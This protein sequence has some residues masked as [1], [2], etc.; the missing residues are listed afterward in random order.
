M[1]FPSPKEV[2]SRYLGMSSEQQ[3]RLTAFDWLGIATPQTRDVVP[4]AEKLEHSYRQ[5]ARVLHPDKFEDHWG[6]KTASPEERAVLQAKITGIFTKMHSAYEILHGATPEETREKADAYFESL[7]VT[8]EE[9]SQVRRQKTQVYFNHLWENFNSLNPLDALKHTSPPRDTIVIDGGRYSVDP[10]PLLDRLSTMGPPFSHEDRENLKSIVFQSEKNSERTEKELRPYIREFIEVFFAVFGRQERRLLESKD[11]GSSKDPYV[12]AGA[13]YGGP[14]KIKVIEYL[15]IEMTP[16]NIDMLNILVSLGPDVS[17]M[18][19]SRCPEIA[20][21]LIKNLN[22]TSFITDVMDQVHVLSALERD[23]FNTLPPMDQERYLQHLCVGYQ[24]Q[25]RYLVYV[26]IEDGIHHVYHIDTLNYAKKKLLFP[27]EKKLP[28]HF[29]NISHRDHTQ[30][31]NK[32]R[33]S[34]DEMASV[35]FAKRAPETDPGV[36]F[37]RSPREGLS[38]SLGIGVFVKSRQGIYTCLAHLCDERGYRYGKDG[39][40]V[41]EPILSSELLR[42][43]QSR[44]SIGWDAIGD[45]DDI[46]HGDIKTTALLDALRKQKIITLPTHQ[47]AFI[48]DYHARVAP[49]E[50]D[51]RGDP[52]HHHSERP[53]LLDQSITSINAMELLQQN[54]FAR[55]NREKTRVLIENILCHDANILTLLH[56]AK[57]HELSE[58][59]IK[60]I[61]MT[62]VR[63]P[64]IASKTW[65]IK[66]IAAIFS[67]K[68]LPIIEHLFSADTES[69][70]QTDAWI[71]TDAREWHP[72][73]TLMIKTFNDATIDDACKKDILTVLLVFSASPSGKKILARGHLESLYQ[74]SQKVESNTLLN[75]KFR[76]ILQH[77]STEPYCVDQIQAHEPMA[78][79]LEDAVHSL[80]ARAALED[81]RKPHNAGLA[82]EPMPFEAPAHTSMGALVELSSSTTLVAQT[83]EQRRLLLTWMT[84]V[85]QPKRVENERCPTITFSEHRAAEEK[86]RAFEAACFPVADLTDP[87]RTLALDPYANYASA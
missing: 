66:I 57:S 39:H 12:S 80:P 38:H 56:Q 55:L 52:T 19:I 40:L 81:L 8:E 14:T 30:L 74:I 10:K 86:Q 60:T 43:L 32:S 72:V 48:K 25:K 83:E 70:N 1:V 41:E 4:S 75:S 59:F 42:Y 64:D 76:K 49:K 2:V 61:L 9:P 71:H 15:D 17:H 58:P 46:Q 33:V 6:E 73:I 53:M 23:R 51:T 16:V 7:H 67:V 87:P 68:D 44:F 47:D 37:F 69:E 85:H 20:A 62:F 50:K 82:S 45:L 11:T 36:Y 79:L 63:S 3:D 29:L 18:L 84:R 13:G 27:S 24:N 35:L 31:W 77:M 78:L 28:V 26:K 65:L 54:I 34:A 22:Q 21:S 5:M